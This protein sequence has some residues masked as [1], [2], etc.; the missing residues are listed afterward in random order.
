[1]VNK[2]LA[3]LGANNDM[4]SQDAIE[5]AA[6]S[7]RLGRLETWSL[8]LDKEFV[9]FRTE[10]RASLAEISD[11]LGKSR[12]TNWSVVFSGM[13]IVIAIYASAIRPLNK[14][15]DRQEHSSETL[16]LA[17]LQKEAKINE[18]G[19]KLEHFSELASLN[20]ERLNT[21]EKAGTPESNLR[22]TVLEERTKMFSE[23]LNSIK[24]EGSPVTRERLL[25]IES[26]LEQLIKK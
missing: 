9:S 10:V 13:A 26:Q 12:E 5:Q 17:V 15:M 6:H 1:M 21:I 25:K 22:L 23:T 2:P 4:D 11:K 20:R 7:E 24:T 19:M 18:Q 16:A 3:R 14:D 8:G